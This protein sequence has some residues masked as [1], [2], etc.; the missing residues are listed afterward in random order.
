MKITDMKVNH[1]STPIGYECE[2][3]VFSW[4][5]RGCRGKFQAGVRMKIALDKYMQKEV[6]DSEWQK[7]IKSTGFCPNVQLSPR[8]RYFWQVQVKTEKGERI[9][10]PISWF[11]T[12]KMEEVWKGKWITAPFSLEDPSVHPLM[13]KNFQV[14]ENLDSARIYACGLGLFELYINGNKVSDE[15]L[16][17]FY[18]DYHQWIQYVTY[19]ITPLLERGKENALGVMLGNGWYKGRFSYEPNM[20]ELYGNLFQFLGEIRMETE[21]GKEIL[22][23]SDE[24]WECTPSPVLESSIYDGEVYDAEKRTEGFSLPGT[25]LGCRVSVAERPRGEIRDRLSPPLVITER[26]KPVRL[27]R[28]PAGEEVLDF[29]QNMTGW[30]EFQCKEKAGTRIRLQYGEVLQNGN[31]YRD[32]LR[33]AKAEMVYISD[34]KEHRVRPHFTFYGFRYV[35]V[36]GIRQ[37]DPENF[38]ACV[39][40]SELKRCGSVY[41]SNEKVNRLFK[42]TVWGQ[43]GNFLDVPTDCPQRDERLGWT[44]DAQAFCAAAS[45]HMETPAFYRKYL[46]DMRLAQRYY[47]GGVP[48]VVPD[49]LAQVQRKKNGGE[50][51]S[52]KK[53]EWPTFGSCAWG[54]AA[55]ILPWTLYCFYGDEILLAEQYPLM[56]DWV[57]YIRRIDKTECGDSHLWKAGFHFGD[58][59]ALDNPDKKSCFG[60]TD[61]TYVATAF[62]YWSVRITAKA[63]LVLGVREDAETYRN[64][65]EK[66]RKAFQNEYFDQQGRLSVHTQT[67]MV[68]ALY[69]KL[70]PRNSRQRIKEELRNNIR[71]QGNHLT[72]GFV[73][74]CY[75]C[76]VLSA[77]GMNQEAYDL[78][79]QEEYPGWLYEVNMGATTV[80]ERW[81]SILPDGSISDTGMNSLNHYAY[82]VIAEWLYRYM[83]GIHPAETDA[84]FKRAVLA[85]MPDKRIKFAQCMY[86]SASGT[87][88]SSWN[89]EK[90][91]I[92][93]SIR[94]PFD[95]KAR[96]VLPF[97]GK[98]VTVNG[99]RCRQLEETG[100]KVFP[101]GAYEIYV[102]N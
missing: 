99:R 97:T 90:D 12:G 91:G 40:H 54:D 4:I 36:T 14:P 47:E 79:L 9:K 39:L 72:T 102:K 77:C 22:I 101:A 66:I 69:F 76:P 26:K 49:V 74:T 6:Y 70:A 30:V 82:G 92:L 32:N 84:G 81:N 45:F 93:F 50:D 43:R 58:W 42:N 85:P 37:T 87:Y 2:Y 8:T 80:W 35:K 16:A 10:S 89:W 78:L 52:V 19:D 98:K 11:E 41:T 21:E 57:E 17:P 3:P 25:V 48:H 88:E 27:I 96:F 51:I 13:Q 28:T 56:R 44:G 61:N 86:E 73:G 71:E 83:C 59:L 65:S 94:I 63:A 5:T 95:A 1:I 20:Q 53:G 38:T 62:Y 23:V 100:K 34:G 18:T 55:V 31:F 46:Y 24:T 67:A 68:L 60:G 33:T 15:Y 75:L 64:L 7:E 29:G